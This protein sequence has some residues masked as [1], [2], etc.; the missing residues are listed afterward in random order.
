MGGIVKRRVE[1]VF[2]V[3][4]NP[5]NAPKWSLN[6]LEEKL[7]S[8]RPVRVGTTRRAVVKSLGGRTAESHAVCTEFEPNRRISWR[9]TSAP[10]PFHVTVD[11]TPVDGGTQVDST[12]TFQWTGILRPLS[13]L[14]DRYFTR[15]MRRDVENLARLM[16]AGD[17]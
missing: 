14:V 5:E 10:F 13:P 16:E 15:V 8:E 12:W 1:D 7:T 3:L 9:T 17:L 4:S 6:A 11:F 2:A